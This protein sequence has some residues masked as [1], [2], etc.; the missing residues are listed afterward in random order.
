MRSGILSP[1][2]LPAALL[3]WSGCARGTPPRAPGVPF[4]P[5]ALKPGDRVGT[6]VVDSRDVR[7]ALD[8]IWVGTVRFRGELTLDGRTMR[9]PDSD[10]VAHC[11]EADSVSAAGIPRWAGDQ[12]RPWFCFSNPDAAAGTLGPAS[13]GGTATIV[14]DEFTI[15]RGLSDEVNSARFVRA[16]R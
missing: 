13:E 15:H 16:I 11:F 10:V 14:I 2:C 9:H 6:L 8:S 7:L 3:L 12:R 5:E 4:D 1:G